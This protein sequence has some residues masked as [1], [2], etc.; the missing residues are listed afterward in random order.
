MDEEE[1]CD[2]VPLFDDG[3]SHIPKYSL[4]LTHTNS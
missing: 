1:E 2:L 4:N 3:E